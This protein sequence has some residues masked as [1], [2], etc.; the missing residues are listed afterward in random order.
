MNP[1]HLH[2]LVCP[3]TQ[4]PLTLAPDAVIQ[5]DRIRSGFLVEPESGRRYPIVDAIPRFVSESNYCDSFGLEWNIHSRTQ[6]DQVSAHNT[7][8]ARFA[9]ETRWGW[10]L[11]GET[12]LEPGSGAGRFTEQALKTGATVVSMDY[13]QS[14]VANYASNGGHPNLL[15]VQGS[16]YQMPFRPASF[17]RIFSFGLL[18]YT[19]DPEKSFKTLVAYLKPGGRIVSDVYMK[20]VVNWLLNTKYWVRPFTRGLPPEILYPRIKSYVDFMW[21]LVRLL[22]HVPLVGKGLN[23]R[24]LVADY[25]KTLPNAPDHVLKEWAYMDTFG[26]LAPPYDHPQTLSTF[27]RWHLEAG[28]VDV[29]VHYGYNGVEGRGRKP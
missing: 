1:N 26:M 13:S 20:T 5:D 28:L 12:I 22:R 2:L 25:S 29:D 16:L 23:W 14:V 27:R 10:D 4:R 9:K 3:E 17:D 7:S 8:E 11:A 18:Q 15:L 19:P 24:L 21:P 6:Y